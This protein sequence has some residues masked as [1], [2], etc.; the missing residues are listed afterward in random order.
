MTAAARAVG[1]AD[2]AIAE[3]LDLAEGFL[4]VMRSYSCELFE[5]KIRMLQAFIRFPQCYDV[6]FYLFLVCNIFN[7]EQ[8][9]FISVYS[10]ELATVYY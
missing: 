6:L 1:V 7:S 5:L 4:E 8:K 3:G 10:I 2:E 9:H